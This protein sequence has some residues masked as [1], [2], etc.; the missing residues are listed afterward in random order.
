[1]CL[2]PVFFFVLFTWCPAC[3]PSGWYSHEL[4]HIQIGSFGFVYDFGFPTWF[5]VIAL[6]FIFLE[7]RK[8]Y[9]RFFNK[10]SAKLLGERS[11][12]PARARF[13]SPP[14]GF[15]GKN[16]PSCSGLLLMYPPMLYSNQEVP[17]ETSST[18]VFFH[19]VLRNQRDVHEKRACRR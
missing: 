11:P 5:G 12:P 19:G 13:V 8:Q 15:E 7:T 17:V 1:M 10:G 3:F 9:R 16:T 18:S 14:L 2:I 6:I 4:N